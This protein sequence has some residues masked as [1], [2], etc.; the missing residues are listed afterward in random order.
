[1]TESVLIVAVAILVFLLVPLLAERRAPSGSSSVETWR[2]RLIMDA[3][4]LTP[5]GKVNRW[6]LPG[7]EPAA[8]PAEEP[9]TELER[10][11]AAVWAEVLG[12]PTIGVARA[13]ST[14]W[15]L[16]PGG[17]GGE[18]PGIGSGKER[19]GAGLLRACHRGRP[20]APPAGAAASASAGDSR[21]IRQIFLTVNT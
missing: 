1:M 12:V 6:A 19:A 11:I 10:A 21:L 13:S 2:R 17:P 16:V 18:I 15:K 14:W 9:R 8:A 7:P 5:T 20:V 4:P 3:L